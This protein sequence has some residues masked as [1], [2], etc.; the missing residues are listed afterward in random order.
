MGDSPFS[1]TDPVTLP[2]TFREAYSAV[3][4]FD[5]E[6]GPYAG[7]TYDA[8][9]LLWQALTLAEETAGEINRATVQDALVGLEY[10]GLT[11]TVYQPPL[12]QP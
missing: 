7:P 11:G 6:A 12:S 2:A 3:T 5:E 1:A 4:P 8:F 10:Q 9:N